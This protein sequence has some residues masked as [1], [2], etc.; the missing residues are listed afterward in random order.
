MKENN[1]KIGSTNS[2]L[3]ALWPPEPTNISFNLND[4]EV[5]FEWKD[6][7]FNI[8]YDPDKCT[9]SAKAF[10]ECMLPYLNEHIAEKAKHLEIQ[11]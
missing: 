5:I 9:E 6:G 1:L 11:A 4:I 8:V 2:T 7:K 3:T 10:F